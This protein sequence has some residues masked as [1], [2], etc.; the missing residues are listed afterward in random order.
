MPGPPR[1]PVRGCL[2]PC[3]SSLLAFAVRLC[4]LDAVYTYIPNR[5]ASGRPYAKVALAQ[6]TGDPTLVSVVWHA[7]NRYSWTL[8]RTYSEQATLSPSSARTL[9]TAAL[10]VSLVT[11]PRERSGMV[12]V[13]GSKEGGVD[14][15]SCDMCRAVAAASEVSGDGNMFA[16]KGN[17]YNTENVAS[18][19]RCHAGG[20]PWHDRCGVRRT[21]GG[22]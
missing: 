7:P 2:D 6:T 21:R 5:Q 17:M 12:G 13:S 3:L 20:I 8:S 9:L 22:R 16:P 10:K 11:W 14:I 15:A 19:R 18:F 4:K 1:H